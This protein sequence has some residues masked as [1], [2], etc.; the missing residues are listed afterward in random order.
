[1]TP[2]TELFPVRV[3]FFLSLFYL[4]K[5]RWDGTW[6][7]H[8]LFTRPKFLASGPWPGE[9]PVDNHD[10]PATPGRVMTALATPDRRWINDRDPPLQKKRSS[11][12]YPTRN[13][14]ANWPAAEFDNK[15]ATKKV[16]PMMASSSS[17]REK[18]RFQWRHFSQTDPFKFKYVRT[19][20]STIMGGPGKIYFCMTRNR[21]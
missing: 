6:G 4:Q 14:S 15:K 8:I 11:G 18:C 9:K 16:Y 17:K 21:S 20:S 12:S 13:S 3:H 7:P 5:L 1:M 2:R 10:G 19:S